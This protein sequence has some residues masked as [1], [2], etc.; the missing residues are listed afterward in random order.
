LNADVRFFGLVRPKELFMFSEN[1]R[2]GLLVGNIAYSRAIKSGA[3]TLRV[4][5]KSV[6]QDDTGARQVV[7]NLTYG[8]IELLKADPAEKAKYVP[9]RITD[10]NDARR[11]RERCEEYLRG[12]IGRMVC[13][14]PEADA[15]G[16]LTK[17]KKSLPKP[18][19][20]L[21]SDAVNKALT[22]LSTVPPEKLPRQI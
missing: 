19:Q 6:G 17:V 11:T 20:Q 13:V 14:E 9:V 8:S 2:A 1:G 22:M 12:V 3:E 18:P 15:A 10:A 21:F 16:R 4:D 5:F 7:F